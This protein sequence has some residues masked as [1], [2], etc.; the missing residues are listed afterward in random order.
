M[1]IC[2]VSQA[3]WVM[4][5]MRGFADAHGVAEQ[6]VLPQLLEEAHAGLDRVGDG[7]GALERHAGLP[8][9]GV[10]VLVPGGLHA[11]RGA[12]GLL[13]CDE[14]VEVEL[15]CLRHVLFPLDDSDEPKHPRRGAPVPETPR[16]IVP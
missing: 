2:N 4:R 13:S 3:F 7:L 16:L 11:A 1:P 10:R 15:G 9:E 6:L 8:I 12:I 14:A 5:W